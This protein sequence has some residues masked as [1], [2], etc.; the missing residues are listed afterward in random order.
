METQKNFD[1][2]AEEKVKLFE[3]MAELGLNRDQSY[4]LL[5]LVS[6]LMKLPE[7]LDLQVREK[8]I[9]SNKKKQTMELTADLPDTNPYQEAMEYLGAEKARMEDCLAVANHKFGKLSKK[10]RADIRKLDLD[11]LSELHLALLDFSSV[12]DLRQWLKE[13]A[14][15]EAS[16]EGCRTY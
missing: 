14:K 7:P 16:L 3:R 1:L 5:R 10:V 4:K 8:V 13:R 2:R 9:E 11:A 6:G 15:L 12:A